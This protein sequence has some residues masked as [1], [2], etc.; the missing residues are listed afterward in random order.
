MPAEVLA[1]QFKRKPKGVQE[2]LDALV[3]LGVVQ[4]EAGAY[5]VV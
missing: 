1:A 3:D 5:R 2:V 4:V